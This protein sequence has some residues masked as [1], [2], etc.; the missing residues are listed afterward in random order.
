MWQH[1]LQQVAASWGQQRK[2]SHAQ[3]ARMAGGTGSRWPSILCQSR[4]CA[5]TSGRRGMGRQVAVGGVCMPCAQCIAGSRS[6][7]DLHG[8]AQ[9]AVHT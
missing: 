5:A 2:D 9:T 8:L 7:S 3:P 4:S 6:L 1:P